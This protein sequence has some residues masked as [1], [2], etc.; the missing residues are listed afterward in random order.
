LEF[1][2]DD[3][4][5]SDFFWIPFSGFRASIRSE[6]DTEGADSRSDVEDARVVL[7]EECPGNMR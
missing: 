1:A 2:F 4:E 5:E 7:P 6:G 3:L